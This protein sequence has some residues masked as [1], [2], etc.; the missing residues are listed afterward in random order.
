MNLNKLP[1]SMILLG[2]NAVGLELAQVFARAGVAI[3]LLEKMDHI[4][5]G[6]DVEI[7]SALQGY[8]EQEGIHIIT[9]IET[10]EVSRRKGKYF[11]QGRQEEKGTAFQ[12]EQLLVAT[13]RKPVTSGFG[14][15]E[16]GVE[17]GGRGE[18]LVNEVMQTS[19]PDIYAA[20]DVTGRDQFVYTAAYGAGLAAEN[21]L[22]GT[23]RVYETEYMPRVIFSDPQ[24]AA[25][26]LTE[27][28]AKEQGYDTAVS[29]LPM[30]HVPRALAAR[31]TRGLVKLV[32][33]GK[34]GRILGAHIL[35]SG[36]GEMIQVIVLPSGLG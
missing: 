5:P 28:Q 19:N 10:T 35:T 29:V 26:G 22:T 34:T 13:G 32:A 14:L 20:G 18:I 7:S 3:T 23:G 15:E 16:A 36:A 33:D 2:A 8:L 9:G 31:D 27:V 11:L 12:A 21:A 30:E 6:T 17:L 25:A 24:V 4:A 1:E